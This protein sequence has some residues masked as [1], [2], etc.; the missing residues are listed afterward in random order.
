MFSHS[1]SARGDIA[2][3]FSTFE[4][5]GPY[6]QRKARSLKQIWFSD[7]TGLISQM[8]APLGPKSDWNFDWSASDFG[9]R[10]ESQQVLYWR[11][12]CG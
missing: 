3:G 4:Y 5:F 8:K 10:P 9:N 2:H 1:R 7:T 11:G 12:W 6:G